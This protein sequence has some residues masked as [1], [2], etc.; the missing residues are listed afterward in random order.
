MAQ[1][2]V[3][4]TPLHVPSYEDASYEDVSTNQLRSK[5]IIASLGQIVSS[6][7][8][9]SIDSF[10]SIWSGT[11]GLLNQLA[12]PFCWLTTALVYLNDRCFVGNIDKFNKGQMSKED[13]LSYLEAYYGTTNQNKI[14]DAFNTLVNQEIGQKNFTSL[15]TFLNE[16]SN[17]EVILVA[18]TNPINFEHIQNTIIH[19]QSHDRLKFVLSYENQETDHTKLAFKGLKEYTQTNQTTDRFDVISLHRAINEKSFAN[20]TA[21]G[22]EDVAEQLLNNNQIKVDACFPYNYE[23]NGVIGQYLDYVVNYFDS[24]D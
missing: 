18:S 1:T 8:Y 13:F 3:T 20:S 15:F 16:H 23:Q 11:G 5:V 21:A 7:T 14:I 2:Q 22:S 17:V 12:Y 9:A 10:A 4:E 6:N 24:T 19:G